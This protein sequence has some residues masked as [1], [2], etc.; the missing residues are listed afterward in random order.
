[1]WPLL[2]AIIFKVQSS[3]VYSS[4]YAIK[5]NIDLYFRFRFRFKEI[6]VSDDHLKKNIVSASWQIKLSFVAR[7]L[8]FPNNCFSRNHNIA[9]KNLIE[10]KMKKRNND[11]VDVFLFYIQCIKVKVKVSFDY[12][13]NP[14]NLL[15]FK[16]LFY[17]VHSR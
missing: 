3:K 17:R 13:G 6:S 2:L 10:N 15:P 16:D 7:S 8:L 9:R 14:S 1:M 4:S 5:N 11:N 12:G